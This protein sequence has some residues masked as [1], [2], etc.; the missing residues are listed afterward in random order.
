MNVQEANVSQQDSIR[1]CSTGMSNAAGVI[2]V[3]GPII[4]CSLHKIIGITL[5]QEYASI[6]ATD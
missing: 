3:A 1:V 4:D 6:H 5:F 2:T